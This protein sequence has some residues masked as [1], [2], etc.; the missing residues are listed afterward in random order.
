MLSLLHVL[1]VL[2]ILAKQ[3]TQIVLGKTLRETI[4]L[5]K[6]KIAQSLK[7]LQATPHVLFKKFIVLNIR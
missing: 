1:E 3:V 2:I 5:A 4:E 6:S 7:G